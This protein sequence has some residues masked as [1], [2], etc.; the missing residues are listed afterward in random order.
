[1]AVKVSMDTS[2][3]DLFFDTS[4]AA[5]HIARLRSDADSTLPITLPPL[6]EVGPLAGLCAAVSSAVASVNE[7]ASLLSNE[8]HRTAS[9][10]E[11]FT[12]G[13]VR[14]DSSSARAFEGVQP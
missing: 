1:M 9:N 14:V 11:I 5:E 13:A 6:P 4:T 10:M 7:Q 12:A 8:A 3:S 2:F